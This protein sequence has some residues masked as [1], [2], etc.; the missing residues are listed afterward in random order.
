MS[1][2][3]SS[4]SVDHRTFVGE[5]TL[6]RSTASMPRL[7]CRTLRMQFNRVFF[8]N[9][10]SE[11]NL[12]YTIIAFAHLAGNSP[13]YQ[14]ADRTKQAITLFHRPRSPNSPYT[15]IIFDKLNILRKEASIEYSQHLVMCSADD[16]CFD[17]E[18]HSK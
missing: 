10:T 7:A 4:Y 9:L 12:L 1:R 13:Y 11:T 5:W 6:T 15:S 2:R 18:Q 14:R 16:R 3:S 17:V 8:T